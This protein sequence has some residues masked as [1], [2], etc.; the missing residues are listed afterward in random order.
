[1]IG[2]FLTALLALSQ[3][4]GQQHHNPQHSFEDVDRWVEAFENEERD[5]RQKP[6]EV[7]A[8]L[9][10]APG[11]VVADIGAGTG[12]FTRRFA[13]AVGER[14]IAYGVDL[15]PNM[16][17]YMAKRALDDGQ[18][19]IV[20]VMATTSSPSLAPDSVDLFFV[21]N[22]IH[23]IGERQRYYEILLRTLR[24]DGRL[25]IVDFY[26]DVALD[27]GPS[28]EMRIAKQDLIAEVTAAGFRLTDDHDFLETQYFVVF[29]KP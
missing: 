29:T 21:C 19:N 15:E 27:E 14:G 17:R 1:M 11:D 28:Q 20:P 13:R 18:P 7:V 12:Y 3:H 9:E 25:A 10:L 24:D 26:K 16:L 22:T 2:W 8:A 5:R 23:H 4:Q 6:D